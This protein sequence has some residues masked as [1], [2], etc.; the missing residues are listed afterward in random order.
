M[1][2][3]DNPSPDQ[4]EAALLEMIVGNLLE[5][6]P[7]F[8]ADDD[9]FAAGLDSMAIM[10]LLVMVEDRFGAAIPP[11][12]M[13]TEKFGTIKTIVPLVQKYAT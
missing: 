11:E 3:G 13:T 6:P 5:T 1:N 10:Q 12:E 7:G 2:P 9:L 4:I 8:G